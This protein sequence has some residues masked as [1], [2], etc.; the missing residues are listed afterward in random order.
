MSIRLSFSRILPAAALAAGLAISPAAIAE[1]VTPANL[2]GWWLAIDGVQPAF[3]AAEIVTPTEELLILDASGRADTRLMSFNPVDPGMCVMHGACSDAPLLQHTTFAVADDL[4]TFQPPVADDEVHILTKVAALRPTAVTSAPAWLMRLSAGGKI[5]YLAQPNGSAAR[6]F[7]RIDP[8][9]F[10]RI[11]AGFEQTGHL[12]ID[13]WRCFVAHATVGDTAFLP[14]Q[15]GESPP[16]AW[17]PAF[18]KAASYFAA[19]ATAYNKPP[20]DMT[21][22]LMQKWSAA[23]LGTFL[24]EPFPDTNF[25]QTTAESDTLSLKYAY[26]AARADGLDD[27]AARAKIADRA[28]GE[29][30]ELSISEEEAATLARAKTDPEMLR[31]LACP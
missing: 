19:V 16:P 1:A 30:I 15:H 27:A 6:A 23:P 25:P 17:F 26:L 18:L 11:R 2:A 22:K 14:L 28:N 4:L 8:I 21:D 13:D 24:I 3:W 9:A 10:G 12:I 5:L 31:M 29:T 7:A 20:P